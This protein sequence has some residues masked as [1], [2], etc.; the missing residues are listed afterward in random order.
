MK[1]CYRFLFLL[2]FFIAFTNSY[3]QQTIVE[4]IGESDKIF[5][6][7]V[8]ANSDLK[9]KLRDDIKSGS[10]TQANLTPKRIGLLTMYLF[11]ENFRKRK[12]H[13]TFIYS[14][15]GQSNY[16]YKQLAKPA[17]E[18]LQAGFAK[19]GY[20]LVLP[21]QL[22]NT[23]AKKA[24]LA[25]AQEAINGLD[26]PFLQTLEAYEMT[27][28][29]VEEP[30]VYSFLE[31]GT[32]G[33]VADELAKLAKV[34]GVDAL[35]TVQLSTLYQTS[36]ISFSSVD[37]ILH[38]VNAGAPENEQGCVLTS[39]SLYPDFPYPFVSI[40]N[41]KTFSARFGSYRKLLERSSADY[42]NFTKETI[43]DLF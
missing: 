36:T 29:S 28:T 1:F 21:A 5:F 31:E 6:D 8:F 10:I 42:L 25:S 33:F 41:A 4:F 30:F 23:D 24:A 7:G 18:G 22:F 26:D 15:E 17:I 32:N 37:F 9:K 3:A 39:Y 11:E 20:E 16:F 38:G 14:V 40:R 13:L 12:A 34:L 35:L 27:P 19:S 2:A 43:E